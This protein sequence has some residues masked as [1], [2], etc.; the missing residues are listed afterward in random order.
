MNDASSEQSADVRDILTRPEQA[1]LLTDQPAR[2]RELVSQLVSQA[3]RQPEQ[4]L[5]PA[6]QYMERLEDDI[7]RGGL[8]R[9]FGLTGGE[10]PE[11]LLQVAGESEQAEDI[12]RILRDMRQW[13]EEDQTVPDFGK[14]EQ[15]GSGESWLEAFERAVRKRK[16]LVAARQSS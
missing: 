1:P 3:R 12:Q 5:I 15:A 9:L 7:R 4:A 8:I 16:R 11:D 6:L 14:L 2:R 13:L 10:A